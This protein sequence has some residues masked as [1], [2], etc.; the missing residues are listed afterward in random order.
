[1]PLVKKPQDEVARAQWISYAVIRETELTYVR[2]IF[3]IEARTQLFSMSP[4]SHL[5]SF[6]CVFLCELKWWR[7]AERVDEVPA[8][9]FQEGTSASNANFSY[10]TFKCNE[11]WHQNS[12][13]QEEQNA[14]DNCLYSL[15][16][17]CRAE[18]VVDFIS[19][20]QK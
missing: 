18:N 14:E 1:M 2:R 12:Q 20:F 4:R 19:Q 11:G 9:T 5:P 13:Q 8:E 16:A 7:I 15:F 17:F 6:L 3:L 10:S